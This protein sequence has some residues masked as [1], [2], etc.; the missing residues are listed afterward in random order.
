M[1]SLLTSIIEEYDGSPDN[2][3]ELQ[4]FRNSI[5]VMQNGAETIRSF[6]DQ[7]NVSGVRANG[8]WS[9]LKIGYKLTD[10]LYNKHGENLEKK[11]IAAI[12]KD[13]ETRHIVQYFACS[14]EVLLKLRQ[15][16]VSSIDQNADSPDY[17]LIA[18]STE[19]FVDLFS[20]LLSQ[21]D[22]LI[23][24]MYGSYCG[25]W[26]DNTARYAMILFVTTIAIAKRPGS[27][28]RCIF[29]ARHRGLVLAD[30]VK[31]ADVAYVKRMGALPE[32]PIYRTLVPAL[33]YGSKPKK[34][35]ELM[36]P[37]QTK[38]I[39]SSETHKLEKHYNDSMRFS[40]K[41]KTRVRLFLHEDAAEKQIADGNV[42]VH[43]Q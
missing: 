20:F 38:W 37:R 5:E 14:V 1:C 32:L 15:D 41:I 34:R 36:F 19:M 39:I 26:L 43:C 29:D 27:A 13:E 42:I 22:H 6:A 28:V 7:Y 3:A 17:N 2:K 8:Y 33:L 10:I 11:Q 25:F 23:A 4:T 12:I 24:T 30:L 9:C 21:E 40:T 31:S 18:S 16:S 35:D